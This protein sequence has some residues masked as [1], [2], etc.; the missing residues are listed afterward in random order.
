[1]IQTIMVRKVL[2]DPSS[3]LESSVNH[4]FV[5]VIFRKV[6]V[7]ARGLGPLDFELLGF[8][9]WKYSATKQ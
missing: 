5:A 2:E 6:L 1:M 4:C 3:W 9:F 7:G 8:S